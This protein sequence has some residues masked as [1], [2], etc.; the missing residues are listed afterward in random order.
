MDAEKG[1][2][3]SSRYLIFHQLENPCNASFGQIHPRRL[4]RVAFTE[5]ASTFLATISVL[6]Y[7]VNGRTS[8]SIRYI[9]QSDLAYAVTADTPFAL[10][11]DCLRCSLPAV[12]RKYTLSVLK[13]FG[14]VTKILLIFYL[15]CGMI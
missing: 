11:A 6:I 10:R 5:R 2:Y 9:G 15:K 13:F 3:G 1:R 4:E 14:N 8:R 12:K 7:F